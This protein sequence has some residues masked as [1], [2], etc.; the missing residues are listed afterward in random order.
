LVIFSEEIGPRPVG[1]LEVP[2]ALMPISP[3]P[4]DGML[5]IWAA[6]VQDSKRRKKRALCGA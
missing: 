6:A 1:P 5:M 3:N 2:R 4:D